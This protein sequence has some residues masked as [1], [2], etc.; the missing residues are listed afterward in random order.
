[1]RK[2]PIAGPAFLPSAKSIPLYGIASGVLNALEWPIDVW[3][4]FPGTPASVRP[5]R[6]PS[7][8]SSNIFPYHVD[9]VAC[10]SKLGASK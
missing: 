5:L 1:M 9:S 4:S 2:S 3:T 8:T 10:I 7:Q 6:P